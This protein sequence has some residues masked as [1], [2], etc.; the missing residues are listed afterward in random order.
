MVFNTVIVSPEEHFCIDQGLLH[1]R[2]SLCNLLSQQVLNPNRL[3]G[4]IAGSVHSQCLYTSGS[5]CQRHVMANLKLLYDVCVLQ[6]S[7]N[8]P[9]MRITSVRIQMKFVKITVSATNQSQ[10]NN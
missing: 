10:F 2:P 3:K 6:Q 5:K 7:L 8:I 9:E 4:R 1:Q